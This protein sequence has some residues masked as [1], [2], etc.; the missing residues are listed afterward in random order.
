MTHGRS[1]SLSSDL[2]HD[3]TLT[4]PKTVFTSPALCREV[5][6]VQWWSWTW[7]IFF[8]LKHLQIRS[9]FVIDTRLPLC[10]TI[11]I[12]LTKSRPKYDAAIHY[13]RHTSP[14]TD[15]QLLC[16]SWS[17]NDYFHTPFQFPE[18]VS[19]PEVQVFHTSVQPPSSAVAL[20]AQPESL[21]ADLADIL[22]WSI[23]LSYQE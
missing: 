22:F 4:Y 6:G 14:D 11:S 17:T 21:P 10:N 8:Y 9:N 2:P 7:N 5:A 16:S 20:V 1:I 18:S 19:P 12:R 23:T 3:V 13:C 15:F